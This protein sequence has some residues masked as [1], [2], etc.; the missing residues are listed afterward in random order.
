MSKSKTSAKP[1]PSP[2]EA[3][4]GYHPHEPT[5][6]ARGQTGVTNGNVPVSGDVPGPVEMHDDEFLHRTATDRQH[7]AEAFLQ[8]KLPGLMQRYAPDATVSDTDGW[9]EGDDTVHRLAHWR[10]EAIQ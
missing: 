2:E 4:A 1:T 7:R 9:V 3:A 8:G 10:D 6:C 5:G